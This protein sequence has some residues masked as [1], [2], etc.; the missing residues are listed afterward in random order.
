MERFR[1]FEKFLKHGESIVGSFSNIL[2]G[3]EKCLVSFQNN[4]KS[5]SLLTTAIAIGILTLSLV[6]LSGIKTEDLNK[7]LAAITTSFG[8]LIGVLTVISRLSSNG[9]SLNGSALALVG[10]S[11]AVLILSSALKKLSSL[12]MEEIK[13]GLTGIF[14]GN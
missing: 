1:I 5:K 3:V 7:A 4:I 6:T 14:S 11:T 13:K 9:L 8:E 10:I 2:S 12:N